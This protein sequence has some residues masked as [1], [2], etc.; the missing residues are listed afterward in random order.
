ML[1]EPFLSSTKDGLAATNGARLP[2]FL[3]TSSTALHEIQFEKLVSF[4]LTEEETQTDGRTFKE[5]F[6]QP[7]RHLQLSIR[8]LVF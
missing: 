5:I 3:R 8:Q 4:E 1:A 7:N 2:R 6:K